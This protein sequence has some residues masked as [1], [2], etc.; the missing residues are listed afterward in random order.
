M[1]QGIFG[2][3]CPENYAKM[4]STAEDLRHLLGHAAATEVIR[5]QD[6]DVNSHNIPSP[7]VGMVVMPGVIQIPLLMMVWLIRTGILKF[8]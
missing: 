1:K 4:T 7:I 5:G 8:A 3:R 2:R 6:T